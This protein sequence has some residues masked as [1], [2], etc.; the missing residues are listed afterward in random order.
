[1]SEH[2]KFNQGNTPKIQIKV[3]DNNFDTDFLLTGY[4]IELSIKGVDEGNSNQDILLSTDGSGLI[5]TD[6]EKG[7][8]LASLTALQTNSMLG[9]YE[10]LVTVKDLDEDYDI[11]EGVIE[12]SKK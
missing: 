7:L 2:L 3:C 10:Y 9:C 8:A 4:T 12:V 6:S 11:A 1:M 5:I